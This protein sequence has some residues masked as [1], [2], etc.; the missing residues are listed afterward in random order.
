LPVKILLDS[1]FLMVPTQFNVD[2]YSELRGLVG[3][4]VELITI[5]QVLEEL[6]RKASQTGKS[7]S[8]ARLALELA[9]RHGVRPVETAQSGSVDS[10]IAWTA[11]RLGCPVATND[12]RLR[13]RL[14]A[15]AVPV[16]YLRER[17]HL[18]A[19]GLAFC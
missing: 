16:V 13:S 18:A 9:E 2:I 11:I 1:N 10:L 5:P 6:R 14:R 8:Q 19:S 12:R 3:G 15:L 4:S 7:A 17:T